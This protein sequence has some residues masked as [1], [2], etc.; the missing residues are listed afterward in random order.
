MPL[1]VVLGG[2]IGAGKS[3]MGAAMRRHG[4]DVIDA[5]LVGHRV[6]EPDG[7]AYAAVA[8]R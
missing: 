8:E 6:L 3:A 2:G 5:D 7:A 4:A 1:L